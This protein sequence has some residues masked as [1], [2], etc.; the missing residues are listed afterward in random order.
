MTGA[1]HDAEE[2]IAVKYDHSGPTFYVKQNPRT[3]G[4]PVA[5]VRAVD[6]RISRLQL[7]KHAGLCE[8]TVISVRCI[9]RLALWTNR[10]VRR[11][12]R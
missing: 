9:A 12:R 3:L 4:E 11:Q 1:E 10:C 7:A 6:L 2:L 5:Y 8:R